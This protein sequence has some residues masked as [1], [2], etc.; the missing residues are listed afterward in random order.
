MTA[1]LDREIK[2]IESR[3]SSVMEVNYDL[4]RRM[5]SFQD[6]K[7]EPIFRW[8]H[9]RE[10]FSKTLISYILKNGCVPSE[11]VILDPFSGTGV[12]VFT[13][14]S[15][16]EMDGFCIELLP[17][18]IFFMECRKLFLEV[19]YDKVRMWAEHALEHW[20]AWQCLDKCWQFS[21]LNITK[22][23]FEKSTEDEIEKFCSWA[24]AQE[25]SYGKFLKFVVFSELESMSYSR[26]DGQYLRWDYRSPRFAGKKQKTKFSKGEVHSFKAAIRNKLKKIIVDTSPDLLSGGKEVLRGN[27]KLVAGSSLF[28]IDSI[29][30]GS[31]DCVITSPPYCNRYD[32]TRTYALEL[33]FLGVGEDEL[34]ALR[35]SL[36]SCTVENKKKD[37]SSIR[38]EDV[39]KA[40]E[41]ISRQ[42]ALKEYLN[43]LEFEKKEKRL[44][45]SG[46][47]TMVEG[48]F[49]ETC[50]HLVQ[51]FKKLKAGA[52]YAMVNDNVQYNG[53]PL[54]VDCFLSSIASDIG[55]DVEKIWI[56]PR[57]KG[58]SSQQMKKYGRTE[59]RKG[60]YIWR[61]PC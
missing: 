29:E 57:G 51:I 20:G 10:G 49:F 11:G 43:F 41:V 14:V 6:N 47:L 42:S 35:Q 38:E 46:I 24:A 17:V 34:K 2:N 44:N 48:Y 4:D 7:S 28:C 40:M 58:N 9:Y 52:C 22:G 27:I 19:G 21:H 31:V 36:L 15:L 25:E 8:F 26:K 18:G 53:K 55:F 16:Y 61:K 45:N 30:D 60:I 50:L 37:F 23:A 12:S 59:L 54:P 56:L 1:V 39:R 5:V 13:G 3:F 33:A 32:Y